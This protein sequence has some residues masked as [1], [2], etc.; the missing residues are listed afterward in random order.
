SRDTW[1]KATPLTMRWHLSRWPTRFARKKITIN[2]RNRSAKPP[3]NDR[4]R[5][6]IARYRQRRF[7]RMRR[8]LEPSHEPYTI[9]SPPPPRP[10]FRRA[11]RIAAFGLRR[12][13][14]PDL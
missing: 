13:Q 5:G 3:S 11:R 2:S 12:Q 10:A 7:G 1:E 9:C 6:I 8:L 14:H 4:D